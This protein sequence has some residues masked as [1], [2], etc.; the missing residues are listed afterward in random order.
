MS[1]ERYAQLIKFK[2]NVFYIVDHLYDSDVI[3]NF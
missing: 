1:N 2:H 3:S